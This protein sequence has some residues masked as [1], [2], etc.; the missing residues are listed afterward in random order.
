MP[1]Q[2]KIKN[3]PAKMRSEPTNKLS[4]QEKNADSTIN[5]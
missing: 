3:Q 5:A 4:L 2:L 1:I